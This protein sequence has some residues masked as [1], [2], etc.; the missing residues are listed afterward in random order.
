[1]VVL[2]VD[3][4]LGCRRLPIRRST[5]FRMDTTFKKLDPAADVDA[6]LAGR[7][8]ATTV[9]LGWGLTRGPLYTMMSLYKN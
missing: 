9:R 2:L 3:D 8:P 7:P 1:L 6:R 4:R 5:Q